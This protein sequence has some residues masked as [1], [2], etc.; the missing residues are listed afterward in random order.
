MKNVFIII[1]LSLS[2]CSYSQLK[3]K[4]LPGLGDT[5]FITVPNIKN[6]KFSDNDIEFRWFGTD[7]YADANNDTLWH[8]VKDVQFAYGNVDF[9]ISAIKVSHTGKERWGIMWGECQLYEFT[10]FEGRYSALFLMAEQPS[11]V[12]GVDK[13]HAES[14]KKDI[15]KLRSTWIEV[16]SK[17][18]NF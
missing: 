8:P 7:M 15:M 9:N 10:D 18:S 17:G 12:L 4:D 11:Y 14:F 5:E 16:G 6:F 13:A 3:I 2:I 1:G